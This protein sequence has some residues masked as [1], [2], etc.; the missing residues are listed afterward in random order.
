MSLQIISHTILD[1]RV[2]MHPLM[3]EVHDT[4]HAWVDGVYTTH[5]HLSLWV[6][7]RHLP[8]SDRHLPEYF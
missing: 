4:I 3:D 2:S 7:D 5:I 8:E 6:A 1:R